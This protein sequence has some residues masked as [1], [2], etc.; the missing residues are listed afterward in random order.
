[1]SALSGNQIEGSE[2]IAIIGMAGRFPG[3]D[4]LEQFWRNIEGGIE[5][6]TFFSEDELLQSGISREDLRRANYVKAKP[7]LSDI[8]SFDA[9]FFR[10]SPKE[11]ELTD[12]QHRLFLECAWEALE[13]AAYDPSSCEERI[14]V[15]ASASKNTY[16]LFNLL[17]RGGWMNTHDVYQV[18]VGNE[19]DYL[20]TRISYK[21]NLRGPSITV[22]T[23]CSSSLVAI[24][25]ACQSLINGECDIALAGGVAIDAPHKSGYLSQPG[26]VLSSDG[27]CRSFDAAAQGT[28][29]GQGIGIVALR[30]LDDALKS[31]DSVQAIILGS[32][33]NNDGSQKLSFTAPSVRGQAEVILEAMAVANVQPE[34]ITYVEAHGTATHLGDVVEMEALSKAFRAKTLRRQY[35]AL[36]SVK[37]NV[38]HL[39]A[40]AGVTGLIKTVLALKHKQIPPSLHFQTPNPQID[41]ANSPFFVNTRLRE[42]KAQGH[43]RQAG[44][45]SFGQGGTNCHVILQEAPIQQGSAPSRRWHFLPISAR[46]PA[47][48]EALSKRLAAHLTN[49]PGSN[50]GDISY[51]LQVGR[52]HFPYRRAVLCQD[53]T[54]AARALAELDRALV[55]DCFVEGNHPQ[56]VF[57]FPIIRQDEFL[58]PSETYR[59]EPVF[60]DDL[61]GCLSAA[62]PDIQ[63]ETQELLD[64]IS[65]SDAPRE[66][67]VL[68]RPA[69]SILVFAV[70]Y[71]LA[72]LLISWGVRPA[73]LVADGVGKITAAALAGVLT[74]KES[75]DL[76]YENKGK[77]DEMHATVQM[78]EAQA[79]ASKIPILPSLTDPWTDDA[80]N[81]Q[82]SRYLKT[83]LDPSEAA[84][85]IV[86]SL[87]GAD[88]LLLEIASKRGQPGPARIIPRA[89][90]THPGPSPQ[91]FPDWGKSENACLSAA[92]SGVW[93]TGGNCDWGA[94]YA[95]EVRL[96]VPLPTYP[97]ER[98]RYWIDPM[99]AMNR[100]AL[101]D[102]SHRSPALFRSKSASQERVPIHDQVQAKLIEIVKSAL[103]LESL[104][105]L[106]NFFDLGG[107]SLLMT[108]VAA[109]IHEAFG[110]ELSVATIF[111]HP[112]ITELNEIIQNH[113]VTK[114][115]SFSS[116][117][118]SDVLAEI[119]LDSD[120]FAR[121]PIEH[122]IA[123]PRTIL[124]T[125]AS[126][127]LGA[128]LLS[129][130][131]R[132]TSA[133]IYCLL[134]AP[135]R[136]AAYRKLRDTLSYYSLFEDDIFERVEVLLGDLGEP[137]LG[138]RDFVFCETA[139]AIDA[140]YHAGALVNFLLPYSALKRTN[141]FGQQEI[142]RLAA[143]ERTKPVYFV[144]S[145][146]VYET[147]AQ[148]NGG[149]VFE[150]DLLRSNFGFRNPYG[151]TKWMSEMLIALGRSRGIPVSIFRAGNIAG[152]SQTG[153]MQDQHIV[154]NFIQGC[155]QLGAAPDDGDVINVIPVDAA[156]DTII[157]LSLKTETLGK[158]FHVTNPKPA[159]LS[160]IIDWMNLLGYRLKRMPGD[161]WRA[162]VRHSAE[163][164][165]FKPFLESL[166]EGPLFSNLLFDLSNSMH[167]APEQVAKCPSLDKELLSTYVSY[168]VRKGLIR[169]TRG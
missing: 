138:L 36:G 168:L 50:I 78:I 90:V 82:F 140:I 113:L 161:E 150:A 66:F 118:H 6:I 3:A 45:N 157:E 156:A 136:D 83:L 58:F 11:A 165:A 126:G 147:G 19:K 142:L 85:P 91:A 160:D 143:S 107:H 117:D 59:T 5:S 167:W 100:S 63:L 18:L 103:G 95:G 146:A 86:N 40:A 105:P 49:E 16:L 116:E 24:H 67:A 65:P 120:I 9:D 7:I 52:R 21:L 97:F 20:S 62:P 72:K 111:E 101:E 124:L 133:R 122:D 104:D 123:A 77:L 55:W 139:E 109:D 28:V 15:Y 68:D 144:S 44:I 43:P 145:T 158:T 73:L 32:A 135:D 94:Y 54:Q 42:W 152:H 127:F 75:V 33:V 112:T 26:D 84:E 4:T 81:S 148:K 48:L 61:N 99:P 106:D 87:A 132:R 159:R 119:K 17:S 51:T 108:M 46:T 57:V 39:N 14:G 169:N 151:L 166:A 41:F 69:Y 38:G 30:R 134:R 10:I 130:L 74:V 164:N 137:K 47:A 102:Q 162:A 115:K 70:Q 155:I 131:L 110:L 153:I 125:G 89:G 25:L 92:L 98:K 149:K 114:R 56:S 93:I 88:S 13:S 1:M 29:F 96:R 64:W 71:S 35:C 22:Q 27:H 154:S 129:G 23:A 2:S 34:E 12:P 60:R 8:E 76:L 121:G 53:A 37:T 141:V 163:E 80:S 128:Y 79:R 31:G